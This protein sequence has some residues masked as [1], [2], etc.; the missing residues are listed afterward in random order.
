MDLAVDSAAAGSGDSVRLS[1]RHYFSGLRMRDDSAGPPPDAQGD[2]VICSGRVHSVRPD[3]ES[4]RL[5]GNADRLPLPS[6]AG[7]CADGT[8]FCRGCM[9]RTHHLRHRP[10]ITAAPV[11]Q[12]G[13]SRAPSAPHTRRPAGLGP[14]A[15]LGRIF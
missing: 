9:D 11:H 13:D 6:M 5:R 12:T 14:G 7:L 8:G 2:A 1:A 10:E 3:P 4:R 15:Y